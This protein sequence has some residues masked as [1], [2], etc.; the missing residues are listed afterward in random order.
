MFKCSIQHWRKPV[1][2]PQLQFFVSIRDHISSSELSSAQDCSHY[3]VTTSAPHPHPTETTP[4]L[5]AEGAHL[6]KM[7]TFLTINTTKTIPG[8]KGWLRVM[9]FAMF[10]PLLLLVTRISKLNSKERKTMKLR[11]LRISYKRW[12]GWLYWEFSPILGQSPKFGG[13]SNEC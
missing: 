1:C 6:S 5:L 11:K 12:A 4:K 10:F 7:L 13:E 9:T 8:N 3:S 2:F